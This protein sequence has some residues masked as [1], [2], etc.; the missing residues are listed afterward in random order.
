[1]VHPVERKQ[2]LSGETKSEG[3]EVGY[4]KKSSEEDQEAEK[5]PQKS[6]NIATGWFYSVS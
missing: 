4:E 3:K 1:M 6:K 2:K 5:M